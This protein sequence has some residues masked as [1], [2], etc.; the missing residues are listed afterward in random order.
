[1]IGCSRTRVRKQPIIELYFESETVLKLYSLKARAMSMYRSPKIPAIDTH[2][3]PI[4]WHILHPGS[5]FVFRFDKAGRGILDHTSFI[6]ALL[7]PRDLA[8]W[9]DYLKVALSFRL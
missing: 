5:C 9:Q 8:G 2:C 7:L 3:Q 6:A 1:M 4:I